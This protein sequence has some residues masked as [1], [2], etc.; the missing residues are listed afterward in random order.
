MLLSLTF[1]ESYLFY[2]EP[3]NFND[4]FDLVKDLSIKQLDQI[5]KN[6]NNY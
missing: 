1:N 3:E 2:G 5:I 4:Y 6:F